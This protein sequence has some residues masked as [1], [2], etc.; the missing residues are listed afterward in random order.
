MMDNLV[1]R[2]RVALSSGSTD[3]TRPEAAPRFARVG[4]ARSP[5][6]RIP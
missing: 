5:L 3:T 6:E 2:F 4:S 1:F